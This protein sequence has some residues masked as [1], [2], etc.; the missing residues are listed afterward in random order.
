[1]NHGL[2]QLT[3]REW[4]AQMRQGTLWGVMFGVSVVLTIAAPFETGDT[5]R[6]LPRFFYWA[7]LVGLGYGIGSLCA[8]FVGQLLGPNAYNPVW[9]GPHS[10]TP[11][12]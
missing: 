9:F 3:L 11:T 8:I 5:L 1:V 12:D 10:N 7:A 6:I 2:L 4:G